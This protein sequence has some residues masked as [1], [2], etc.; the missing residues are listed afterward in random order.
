MPSDISCFVR[1]LD[2]LDGGAKSA[3]IFSTKDPFIVGDR[4]IPVLVDTV[5]GKLEMV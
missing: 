1:E 3:T 5:P 4:T 2:E